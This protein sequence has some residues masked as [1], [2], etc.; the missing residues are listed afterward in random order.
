MSNNLTHVQKEIEG[1]NYIGHTTYNPQKVLQN[2]KL[3]YLHQ[4][5]IKWY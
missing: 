4:G 5:I 1:F 2:K 3:H